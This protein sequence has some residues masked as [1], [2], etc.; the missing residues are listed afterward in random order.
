[1]A[2]TGRVGRA[3]GIDGSFYVEDPSGS[4]EEGMTLTLDGN[5]AR[6]ER[7][8][9]LDARPLI[10]LSGVTSR[11][12]ARELRGLALRAD[13]GV[14]PELGPGEWLTEDLVG[15]RV[16]GLGEVRRVVSAPSCDLLVVGDEEVL[17]PLVP[18]A[19]RSVDPEARRIDV[20]LRFL[21][22]ESAG[23]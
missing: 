13:D 4:V 23:Q 6:V 9:G 1:V 20:D 22:L 15:C 21:G 11:E 19:V 10:R 18:D 12:A 3:H 14:A 8:G 17:V 2:F 7:R 16:D 5:P